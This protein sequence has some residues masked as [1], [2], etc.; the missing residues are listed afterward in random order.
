MP[1]HDKTCPEERFPV[2]LTAGLQERT[3]FFS[4][5]NFKPLAVYYMFTED[6]IL[7]IKDFAWIIKLRILLEC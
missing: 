7:E 2:Y 6:S 4:A 1:Q 3:E 5:K